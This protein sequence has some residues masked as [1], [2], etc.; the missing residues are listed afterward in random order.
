MLDKYI[1]RKTDGPATKIESI[2][3]GLLGDNKLS[4][5]AKDVLEAAGASER[6]LQ[7]TIARSD[8]HITI[9]NNGNIAIKRG[10][11]QFLR[12]GKKGGKF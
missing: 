3:R 8:G 10:P 2:L 1:R 12:R 9:D 6:M 4:V 5:N 11:L 7:T